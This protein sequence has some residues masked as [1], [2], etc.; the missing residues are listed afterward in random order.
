MTLPPPKVCR[1]IRQLFRL[2]GSS[3]SNEAANAREKLIA[4]LAKHGLSWLDVPA[5]ITLAEEDDRVEQATRQ[6]SPYGSPSPGA[7]TDGP[8]VNVLDLV[9]RLLELH[10]G[11]TPEQRMA[12]ALWALHSYVFG[13]YQI[14]PRLAMVSPVRGCGKTTLL[15]LLEQTCANADRSDS[16]TAAS[17]YHLIADRE[18]T[19]LV[20]EGDNLGLFNN[21]VLRAVFNAGHRRG[22][23]VR[24]FVGG[25]S[26]K[27]PVFVPLAVAAIGSLPLPL[28]HRAVIINMQRHASG[29]VR[30]EPVNEFDPTFSAARGQIQKWATTCKL[31]PDPEMPCELSNRAADNWRVLF[32]I[33]DDLGHGQEAR[34]AAIALNVNRLDEDPGIVLLGDIRSIFDA[35]GNDRISSAVLV[36]NLL[37]LDSL[38]SDWRGLRDDRPARKL[39]QSELARLLRPFD[40]QPRSIWPKGR[41]T[42]GDSRKGYYRVQFEAAWAA[43]CSPG[44]TSSQRSTTIRL[45]G[46]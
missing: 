44:G 26:R 10:V 2:I 32:A 40:I 13:R 42:V 27:F 3:N 17:I 14:T 46:A 5:C 39:N 45:L 22:G 30:L 4:L 9:L 34:D 12:V 38:W 7:P 31:N 20:D 41:H 8:Q 19:L 25:R 18:Y 23:A 33:A 36:A 28:M 21:P 11:L 43:Y 1:R 29:E 15:V 24:R 6:G 35:L 16:V 37:V